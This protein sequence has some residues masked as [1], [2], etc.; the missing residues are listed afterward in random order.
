MIM[1]ARRKKTDEAFDDLHDMT[2]VNINRILYIFDTSGL[3]IALFGSALITVLFLGGFLYDIE[4]AQAV[5]LML[6]PV[7]ILAALSVRAS[8]RIRREEL[9]RED[10]IKCLLRHRLATQFIGVI[11]IFVTALYGMYKNLY[12]GP[13]GGF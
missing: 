10:L 6:F 1:R 5:I 7:S 11:S 4:F 2:R 9:E 13:F 3:W 8:R 12:T